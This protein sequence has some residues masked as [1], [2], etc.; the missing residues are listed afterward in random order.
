VARAFPTLDADTEA[1]L[2]AWARGGAAARAAAFDALFRALREPVLALCL[3]LTGRRADAEDALQEAFAQVHRGLAAFRGEARL[4]TWVYRIALREALRSRG[5]RRDHAALDP[6]TPDPSCGEAAA[7]VRHE[8]ARVGAA[9]AALPAEHRAV[10]SLFAL[11]GLGHRA[12]AEILGVPEGTA[13]SRLHA[14][15]RRLAEALGR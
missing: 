15:R 8:A 4:A 9:L 7:L 5:R 11:E 14:A 12:I 3:H 1:R 6:E 13:W 10:L 2:V